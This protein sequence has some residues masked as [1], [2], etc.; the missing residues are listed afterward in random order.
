ML[1]LQALQEEFIGL[2][3]DNEW[4]MDFWLRLGNQWL[5]G[6]CWNYL[7]LCIKQLH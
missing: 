2:L 4:S 7:V 6:V 3:V 1:T 5:I